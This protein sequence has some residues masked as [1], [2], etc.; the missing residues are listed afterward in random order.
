MEQFVV[1]ARKYRP[2]TFNDVVGQKSHYQYLLNAIDSNHLCFCPGYVSQRA[3]TT[4]ARIEAVKTQPY[5][6]IYQDAGRPS[7][8]WRMVNN[9]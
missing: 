3:E 7:T 1:S 5:R 2:Q 4:C 6:R 9:A 8:E